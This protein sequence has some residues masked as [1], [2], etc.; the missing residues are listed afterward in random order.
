[1]CHS[2]IHASQIE[3]L[4]DKIGNYD[5]NAAMLQQELCVVVAAASHENAMRSSVS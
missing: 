4:E 5:G 3:E 2:Y 1:M